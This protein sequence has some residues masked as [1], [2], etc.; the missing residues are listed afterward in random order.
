MKAVA[1]DTY[2]PPDVHQLK[3]AA[4]PIPGENEVLVRVQ[5][6]SANAADWCIMRADPFLVR[7]NVPCSVW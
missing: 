5:A 7:L 2:G 6:A 3:E 1:Y 4:K